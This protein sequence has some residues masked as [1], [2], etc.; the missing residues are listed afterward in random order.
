MQVDGRCVLV[1]RLPISLL[2]AGVTMD[3]G[4]AYM[5]SISEGAQSKQNMA[6]AL[7]GGVDT[8][9]VNQVV[10][11]TQFIRLVLPLDGYVFWVKADL[12]TRSALLNAMQL[13]ASTLNEA[14]T[15]E[16]MASQISVK[17]S[18]HY[19]TRTDQN[20]AETEAVNAV[21]FTALNPVQ[22][23]NKVQSNTLWIAFNYEGDDEDFDGP[24]TFAFSSRDNYYQ[25]SDLFHY[26]GTAVL[27]VF[28]TQLI[29]RL[30]Q[31][32][33]ADL[34]VSNSLPIW[35]SL[36]NYIPSYLVNDNEPPPYAAV[37][38]EP[39]ATEAL[40]SAPLIGP[41]S[42]SQM[43]S[44]DRVRVT[45]YGLNNERAWRFLNAVQ[46]F[47]FDTML[48]GLANSPIIRDEKRV[49]VELGVLAQKKVIDFEVNYY[50]SAARNVARQMVESA[51]ATVLTNVVAPQNVN[52][53][54]IR[55]F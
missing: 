12:L 51:L 37:H 45:L 27:P 44:R 39:G 41:T 14:A 54:N 11:F 26:R 24:I 15:I 53:S 31:L 34:I 28:K 21:T 42:Q 33:T 25:Q 35:L 17:G 47:S 49:S 13:N 30:D 20:E 32:P 38:I 7:A 10:T 43:L 48:I 4:L 8:L 46:Q 2:G 16:T 23:F 36:S 18:F 22:E 3:G 29:T 5:V 1:G 40:A 52:Y 9:S 50:Q 55:N 6:A 19:A